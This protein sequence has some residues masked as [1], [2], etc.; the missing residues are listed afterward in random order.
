MERVS[1]AP[2]LSLSHTHTLIHT[3]SVGLLWTSD[4]PVA[5]APTCQHTTFNKRQAFMPP[6][7][8]EPLI[9][10][11]ER[12]QTQALDRAAIGL[13]RLFLTISFCA[14]R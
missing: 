14:T 11:S 8:I 7:G 2:D 13:G 6:A 3:H 1:V 9:P 5:E 12:P 10:A 4:R